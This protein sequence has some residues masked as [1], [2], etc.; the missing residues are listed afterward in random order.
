MCVYFA[1]AAFSAVAPT[2]YKQ[3]FTITERTSSHMDVRFTLPEYD[4]KA[5]SMGGDT[6]HQII[7]PDAGTT[8]ETG[9]PEL[10][11]ISMSIAIPRRGG[12]NVSA[13][14]AE[15]S[16]LTQ[17]KAYPV[18][19]QQDS[20]TPKAFVVNNDYYAS[21]SLYPE[22][23]I[24]YSDPWIMRDFRLVTI[25]V[26]P[27]SY[28]PQNQQL[29]VRDNI[30]LRISF[31]EEPGINEIQGELT[32]ISSSFD[33]M[34][35][36]FILNYAD[37]RY[38]MYAN[39]PPKYLIIYGTNSDPNF[40]ASLNEFVLWKKQKGAD[41]ALASTASNEAGSSTTSI[42]N[43]IQAQ[44]N[45]V[46]T[47]PDFVILIGDTTGSYTIPTFTAPSGVGDYPYTH[48]EGTDTV[49][50]AFIGRISAE[51]LS[52]LQTL[53]AKGYLYE[54]DINIATAQWLNRMLLV[55]DWSP[56]GISTVYLSKYIRERALYINPDYTFT[57][58]YGSDPSPT[59]MNNAMNQGVGFFSYRGYLGMSGWSPSASSLNNAYRLPHAVIIT[60]GTGN[61]GGTATTEDF[62]RLGTAAQP[63][64]AVTAIG[65]ATSSTHTTFNNVIH[66][67]IWAGLLTHDM[68]TM[69]EALLH[70]KVYNH[71][72]F[73]VSSPSNVLSFNHWTNL[74]GDPT[75]EVFMGIPNQFTATYQNI[76]PLG[77]SLL[78]VAVRDTSNTA[79]EGACVTLTQNNNIIS[80]G[81]TDAEGNVIMVLPTSM[82]V[83][84]ITITISRHNFKPIQQTIT[85]DNSG[86]LVPGTIVIDDDN[87]GQ[88]VGNNDGA[89]NGGEIVELLFGLQNTGT[90]PISGISGNIMTTNPH[91]T[92]I[93]SAVTYPTINASE[94]GFNTNP[95]VMQVAPNIPH[96]ELLRMHLILTDS[97]GNNYDVSE[98]VQT[99]NAKLRYHSHAIVTGG[100]QFLEPGETADLTIT[101]SNIG[102][103]AVNDV[104]ARLYSDNDLVSVV[105]HTV[106]YGDMLPNIQVTPAAE[107]FQLF[108]RPQVLPGMLIPMRIRMYNEDGYEQWLSFTFT[109][110][111][112]TVTDPLGPDAY[113][114]VIYDDQDT[115]YPECPVY[116]WVGI[117]PA[118]GGL[119]TA[120][121]ISDS[122]VSGNEGDQ[123][124]ATSLAVVNLPFPFQFYGRVYHQITVCSNGFI[125]LG[126]TENAEFRNYRLPGAMG[127]NPMIAAFW[128]D[129]ATGT[130]SGIYT[131]FDRNNHAFVIEWYNMKNGNN[132]SS[133]ETFQIILYDQS[134]H[135]TSLG[136][137]PIKIQYHTFNNIDSQSG[138]RHGNF[139]TIGIEDHSGQVGLEYTFNNQYPTAA[140]P[141]GN[142]RALYITTIPVYH[143]AAHVTLGETYIT[144]PNGNGV[145]EP[146]ETVEL[147]VQLNNIGNVTANNVAATLTTESTFVTILNGYSEYFPLGAEASG[148]NR[149]PFVFSVSP[150]C[151]NG[152]VV[153]FALEIVSGENT[154]TRNFS[155]RVDAS[156]LEYTGF[157]IND[158]DSNYNGIIDPMETVH[159]VV[160]VRNNAAVEA[161]NVM[162]TLSTTANVTIAE[163]IILKAIV[164]ANTVLQFVYDIQFN[165][166]E[167]LGTYIPFQF[168]ASISNG[169]PLTTTLMVPYNMTNIFSDFETENANFESQTG[170]AWGTPQQVTPYSGT[171]VWASNLTGQYPHL[172][173]Y[174]LYTPTYVLEA[175]AVMSFW[176]NYGFEN[177]Y[178]GGNVSIST[179]HGNTWTVIAP[180]GGY[181]AQALNGLDGQPGYTGVSGS[182]QNAA[183]NLSQY[184]GQEVM[185]R[186]VLGSDGATANIGWFIDNFEITNVNQKTGYLHGLVIPTSTTPVTDAV[187][188]SNTF[189]AT[190]PASDGTFRLYL[191]NGTF[192]AT[193]SLKHHQSSTVN[194][195]VIS[196]A[197][198]TRYTEFTL[199]NLPKPAAVSFTV[200]NNTGEVNLAWNEP[201]DPVLPVMAY[202][203]YRKFD[204]GP[205]QFIQETTSNSHTEFISLYGN[206]KY[207]IT[208]RYL[209]T[210]GTPSDTL[211][212]AYPYVDG[213]DPQTPGLVTRL[214]ANY[215]NPFNPTTRISFDLAQPGKAALSVY[216]IKGQLVKTLA[217]GEFASGK[218][219]V[220]WDGRDTK[221][222]P[223]ASGVYFYRLETKGYIK[224][225]KMLL[226]K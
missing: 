119:G 35:E 220:V 149:S 117:A 191:P 59:L 153:T 113:G 2:Q 139:A 219:T 179:N 182:W 49:G 200:N 135:A 185:F 165:T 162:A 10:P 211:S 168:N 161:R 84:N 11:T 83:A 65:V 130:G 62:V 66:G 197:S 80:R 51:N 89:I 47:R 142:Q 186:F 210:E 155:I 207:Y 144:D 223:V 201:Y 61:F 45:N 196:P 132:G 105:N 88:S 147:G 99:F 104:S 100:N 164:D 213:N 127:P 29:V 5:V 42:K 30:D 170:W 218:H 206:Y 138:N 152:T 87:T 23:A 190:N 141:L 53:L 86:T 6:Y 24:Q 96:Q 56:S 13:L 122:W 70:G 202:R 177:N 91:V 41:I 214:N 184:A 129:L 116:D 4:F 37:Y 72:I 172:V 175:G 16:V 55:G 145:C 75:L 64:G 106:L 74:M 114:Y 68:R 109:V 95:V 90:T 118:E 12:V 178:D 181:P 69:G 215:P 39:T 205:F 171:K 224:T 212:F 57:E 136:D 60:C 163:P 79:V 20:A 112:V 110:G 198:P 76:I 102:A 15:Q 9:L 18:Q 225:N 157:L 192:S 176:H 71:Q 3:A 169:M 187:V 17:F 121:A 137:G 48:L 125:A 103:I 43:Y 54:R 160:N 222:R 108:A 195:V 156:V 158:G 140:S 63:K 38:Q 151:P 166:N 101:M 143:E 77:L 133:P 94:L 203:V 50:D 134:V 28:D 221:N 128:D 33:K 107:R 146:G 131:W 189:L 46:S 92:F 199:I 216:N 36:S 209:N 208:V 34:Y 14:A 173:S 204:T 31:T 40:V 85:V 120:L 73:G 8:L 93:Q 115:S 21:G 32:Q 193:A 180:N 82:T 159:L 27:F 188:R 67:G 167:G 97:Q 1:F 98:F 22:A 52:Q 78:D 19:E 58:L 25:Q 126:V 7:M 217:N 194:N 44:Y 124:G 26:N 111:N 150:Q 148:V 226:M 123:V 81:Y 174:H 183:F 154:W